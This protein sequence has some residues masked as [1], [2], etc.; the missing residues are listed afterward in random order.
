MTSSLFVRPSV[1]PHVSLITFEVMEEVNQI[2]INIIPLEVDP[3][4][5]ISIFCCTES[6][7]TPQIGETL[8]CFI[9]V[10]IFSGMTCLLEMCKISYPFF[11]YVKEHYGGSWKWSTTRATCEKFCVQVDHKQVENVFMEL[12]VSQF[13]VSAFWSTA[14]LCGL[15][16]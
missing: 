1:H 13:Y 2:W 4:L 12:I 6:L 7:R 9:W 3:L 11:M 14:D 15:S 5:N 16:V 8:T 10:L